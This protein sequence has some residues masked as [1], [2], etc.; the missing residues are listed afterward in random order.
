M[1]ILPFLTG[2]GVALLPL[3]AAAQSPDT[4]GGGT[5]SLY[6]ENDL[7]AGRPPLNQGS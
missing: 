7:F 6:F 5:L 3:I 1:R 4:S 2:A